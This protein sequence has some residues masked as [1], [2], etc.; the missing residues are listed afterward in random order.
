M[1]RRMRM[2]PSSEQTDELRRLYNINP[3][4]TTEQRQNLASAIGM[5][6]IF[7]LSILQI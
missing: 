2:R 1:P 3:H 5:Y 7:D 6:V 4:P